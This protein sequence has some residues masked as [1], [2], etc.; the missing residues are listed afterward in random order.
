MPNP[1]LLLLGV[2]PLMASYTVTTSP[3]QE[4][5]LGEIVDAANADRA[6]RTPPLP[7]LSRQQYL[8]GVIGSML[9]D[10]IRQR[11]AVNAQKVA[12]AYTGATPAVK[13]QVRTL[14]GVT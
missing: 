6:M 7:A 1:P 11:Q 9:D 3:T 4:T 13:T 10:Y 12:D 5:A 2:K 14:L 8:D